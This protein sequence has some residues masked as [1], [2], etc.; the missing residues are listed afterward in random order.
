MPFFLLFLDLEQK[1]AL[2]KV[3]G[4]RFFTHSNRYCC[5]IEGQG[6]GG[7]L[8]EPTCVDLGKDERTCS[9]CSYVDERD[10]DALGH[11]YKDTVVNPSC[12]ERGNTVH[13]CE[14]CGHTY[15]DSYTD[16][17]GHDFGLWINLTEPTCTTSGVAQRK[18]TRCPQTETK[19][20][21][22]LGHDFK[23]KII[24]PACLDQGYTKHVCSRCGNSYNDTF[25]PPLG[26]DYEEIE[27]EPICTKEGY[28]GKKCRRCDDAI[29]TEILKAVGHKFTDSYITATCEENGYTLHTCLSC[30]NEYKDNIVLATGHDYATEVVREPHCET[31]GERKFHCTK[32]EKEYNSDIPAIGHNYELAGTKEING[33]NVRTYVC[34]N[35]GAT[36]TQNMGDQYEQVSSYIEYLFEQYQ[37]YMWWVLL[38]TA[39]VWSISMGIFF[40]IAQKNEEKEKARKMIKN[41]VIGLAVIF[42]ILVACPYL[43]KGI[44]ALIA[45]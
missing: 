33:E 26:H 9:V 10:I 3:G 40:A 36:T 6:K 32:C 35:C 5:I 34:T 12:T 8:K 30:G 7:F 20:V 27:V 38:A 11:S 22:P 28:R 21:S 45:G 24:E 15:T 29:K 14:R 2:K 25:V 17:A 44:A 39:G 31:K 23:A 4:Q 42:A 19:I 41:Y 1:N 37:P 16:V 13:E 43:V 18:C